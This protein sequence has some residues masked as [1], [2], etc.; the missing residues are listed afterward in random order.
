[1][2]LAAVGR[3][4]ERLVK[5]ATPKRCVEKAE[6]RLYQADHLAERQLAVQVKE[7]AGAVVTVRPVAR[8]VDLGNGDAPVRSADLLSPVPVVTLETVVDALDAAVLQAALQHQV[9][10]EDGEADFRLQQGAEELADYGGR[11]VAVVENL[12]DAVN[13]HPADRAEHLGGI[14]DAEVVP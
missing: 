1:R 8:A 10:V 5:G 11:P 7:H 9:P 14:L 2:A 3:Y 13:R 4:A 6:I 12:Q